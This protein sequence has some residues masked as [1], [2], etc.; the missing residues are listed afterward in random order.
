LFV[1]GVGN[2]HFGLL[3]A[4]DEHIHHDDKAENKEPNHRRFHDFA[5]GG[6]VIV[7]IAQTLEIIF[8]VTVLRAIRLFRLAVVRVFAFISCHSVL[9]WSAVSGRKSCLQA[10]SE[11]RK[12]VIL[13]YLGSA[14]LKLYTAEVSLCCESNLSCFPQGAAA[15]MTA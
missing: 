3:S 6:F 5:C 8:I 2:G 12:V 4:T 10:M 1:L 9:L 7:I 11:R 14:R 13:L 15:N